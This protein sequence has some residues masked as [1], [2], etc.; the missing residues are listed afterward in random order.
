MSCKTRRDEYTFSASPNG[1]ELNGYIKDKGQ[2]L[3]K[4]FSEPE[5]EQHLIHRQ[6]R[7]RDR[8]QSTP[9]RVTSAATPP[10][11]ESVPNPA[12]P[13]VAPALPVAPPPPRL[14]NRLK[15]DGLRTI[16]EE[17]LLFV[18]VLECN[19][20]EVLDTLKYHELEPFTRPRGHYIPSWVREFYF[21]YGELVPRNKKKAS[22]FRPVKSVMVRGKEVECHNKYIDVVLGRLLYSVLPYHGLPI[23][24]SLDDLKGWLAP[25]ISGITPM[26]L[27]AGASIEKSDMNIASRVPW[28]PASD[29]EVTLFSSTNIRCIEA[30]FPREEVDRRRASPTDTSLEVD[31]DSLPAEASSSTPASEPSD[32]GR[33]RGLPLASMRVA[34]LERVTGQGTTGTMGRGALDRPYKWP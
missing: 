26:W 9:I 11:T 29:I 19:H 23:V 18:E 31:V 6:N 7:L 28:D 3:A 14:L 20:A 12:P 10:T 1:R 27:G 21:A 30:E 25:L 33:S 2:I 32:S 16:L 22:E 34:K 8:P 15:G 5:D 13:S 24:P 4:D 17:K